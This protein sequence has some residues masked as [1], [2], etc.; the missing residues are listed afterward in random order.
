MDTIHDSALSSHIRMHFKAFAFSKIGR[1]YDSSQDST[2]KSGND[3]TND[4]SNQIE[5]N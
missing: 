5:M 4:D 1:N 3:Q 2:T